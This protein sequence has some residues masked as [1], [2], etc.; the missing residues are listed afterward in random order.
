MATKNFKNYLEKRLSKAEIKEIEEQAELEFESLKILQHDV[1]HAIAEYMVD[2]QIG[3]NE[4]VRRLGISPTQ[5]AKIQK[6]EANLTLATL[7]HIG[8]LL[9]KRPH[10]VFE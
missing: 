7:A 8:A 6:G 2:E 9:K 3:F 10:L 1:T 4:L 5:M